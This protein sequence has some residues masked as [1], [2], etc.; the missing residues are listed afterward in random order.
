MAA[1]NEQRE[2]SSP[3]EYVETPEGVITTVRVPN[4]PAMYISNVGLALGAMDIRLFVGDV[5]PN[6]DGRGVTATQRLCLIMAP[7]FTKALA[8]NLLRAMG[9]FESRFGKLR[10]VS[11]K[12]PIKEPQK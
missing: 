4:M 3:E 2:T 10:D 12:Q 1:E 6:P 11:V 8:E 7:E 9:T 5:L